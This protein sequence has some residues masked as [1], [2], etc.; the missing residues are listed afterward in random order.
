MTREV[1]VVPYNNDWPRLYQLEI[2]SLRKVLGNEIVSASHIGSTSIPGMLAK[3]IIDILLEVKS[4]SKIDDYND[5]MVKLGYSPRGEY[6]IPDRRYFSKGD[7]NDV[8]THHVH[9]FQSGNIGL[10]RHLAFR[11]YMITH[12]EDAREYAQL[13]LNLARVF[14]WDI[15]GY[16]KGKE[17][18]IDDMEKKA[19]LW[20]RSLSSTK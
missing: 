4:I 14:Q 11:E 17:S 7:S 15:D 1:K 10:E 13:K 3:P 16:C 8:R 18:Y 12:P 20:Y 6:G 19:L 2:V 9:A 5:D